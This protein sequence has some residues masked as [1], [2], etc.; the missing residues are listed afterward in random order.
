[1]GFIYRIVWVLKALWIILSETIN[2]LRKLHKS[3]I[4][5]MPPKILPQSYQLPLV[6]MNGWNLICLLNWL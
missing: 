3:N 5:R 1:M 2:I 6:A 4:F